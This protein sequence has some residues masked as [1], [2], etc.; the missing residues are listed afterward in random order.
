[1]DKGLHLLFPLFSPII[2]HDVNLQLEALLAWGKNYSVAA[3]SI[4]LNSFARFRSHFFLSHIDIFLCSY[5]PLDSFT[6]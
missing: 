1:M 5:Y 3:K 2:S 6:Q 4:N